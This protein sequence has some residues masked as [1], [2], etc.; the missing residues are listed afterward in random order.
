MCSRPSSIRA[1]V[2]R[3]AAICLLLLIASPFT[4]PFAT[5]DVSDGVLHTG[6]DETGDSLVKIAGETSLAVLATGPVLGVPMR[7]ESVAADV[8]RALASPGGAQFPLRL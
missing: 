2:F 6:I 1:L 7:T 5:C 3:A 8:R 4:A